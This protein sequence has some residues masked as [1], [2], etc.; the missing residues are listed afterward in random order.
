ME[1]GELNQADSLFRKVA[2]LYTVH[3]AHGAGLFEVFVMTFDN[4]IQDLRDLAEFIHLE[5]FRGYLSTC[6]TT[7]AC[8][9]VD[10]DLFF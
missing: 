8:E 10:L 4:T 7:L 5:V 1:T 9:S 2:N 3:G 6:T